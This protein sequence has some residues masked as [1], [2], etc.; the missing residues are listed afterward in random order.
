MSEQVQQGLQSRRLR[1]A[2]SER[3]AKE[4]WQRAVRGKRLA[5]KVVGV[6]G[7]FTAVSRVWSG[8]GWHRVYVC[9]VFDRAEGETPAGL[10]GT[11]S[12]VHRIQS[13]DTSVEDKG[14]IQW[15]TSK[16]QRE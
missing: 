8:E 1:I 11:C 16:G 15:E 3:Q 6:L 10:A 13:G 9:G 4:R 5:T 2:G 7:L 14:E 12:A